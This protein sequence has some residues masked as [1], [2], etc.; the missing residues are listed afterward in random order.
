M[1]GDDLPPARSVSIQSWSPFGS[2]QATT[3]PS[4][5]MKT[6]PSAPMAAVAQT[7]PIMSRDH[8]IVPDGSTA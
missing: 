7:S 6:A 1:T 2:K 3:P 4:D 8:F 5:W